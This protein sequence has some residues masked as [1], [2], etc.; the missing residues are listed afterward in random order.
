MAIYKDCPQDIRDKAAH[1]VA[2]YNVDAAFLEGAIASA[3]SA[4][5]DRCAMVAFAA[6]DRKT[7]LCSKIV[8]RIRSGEGVVR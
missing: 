2:N 3:I 4:E 5:R 1:I 8:R 7:E 6:Y